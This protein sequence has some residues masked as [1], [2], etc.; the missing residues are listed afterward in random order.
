MHVKLKFSEKL[1]IQLLI[2]CQQ[3]LLNNFFA[4]RLHIAT[5]CVILIFWKNYSK[6]RL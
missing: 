3:I 2:S 6:I 4:L 5:K 1:H